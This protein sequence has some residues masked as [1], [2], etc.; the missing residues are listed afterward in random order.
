MA[1]SGQTYVK[2]REHEDKCEGT[3]WKKKLVHWLLSMFSDMFGRIVF[4]YWK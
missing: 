1:I 4:N 2:L 3:N